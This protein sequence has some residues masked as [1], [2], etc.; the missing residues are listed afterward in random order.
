MR[1][2]FKFQG[3]TKAQVEEMRAK[4]VV[5]PPAVD[6]TTS[7]TPVFESRQQRREAERKAARVLETSLKRQALKAR[8][9]ER[10]ERKREEMR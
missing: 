5:P 1:S 9:R 7:T 3:L 8:K 2:P 6:A 10:A 4:R